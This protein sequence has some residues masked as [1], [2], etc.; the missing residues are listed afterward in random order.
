MNTTIS[1]A[2]VYRAQARAHNLMAQAHRA[3][4]RVAELQGDPRRQGFY[5]AQ[6]SEYDKMER[7]Y[8]DMAAAAEEPTEPEEMPTEGLGYGPGNPLPIPQAPRGLL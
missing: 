3:D 4:A 7:S 8:L 1:K 2:E 6:A 5:E